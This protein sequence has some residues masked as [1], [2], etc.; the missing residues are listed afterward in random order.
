MKVGGGADASKIILR[1]EQKKKEIKKATSQNH[2]NSNPG[3]GEGGGG[4]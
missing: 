4:R 1:V 2:E 3:V